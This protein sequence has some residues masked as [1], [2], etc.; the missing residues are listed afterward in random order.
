MNLIAILC[1]IGTFI[2]YIL[3]KKLHTKYPYMLLAPGIFVPFIIMLLMVIFNISY[4]TYMIE[5]KWIVWMLGPATIAF[6]IPI[7][8][9]RKVIKEHVLSI[10][11]GIVV[12]MIAGVISA[13]YLAKLFSFDQE[14]TYSLMARSISTPFAMELTSNIGGSVELVILFTMIT[15]IAGVAMADMILLALKLNS[16]FAQGAA[17]GNSAHGFGTSKAFM[18]HR[19]EGVVACLTMVLAGVFM[20][21]LGPGIVHLVVNIL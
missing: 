5:N 10:S 18:R 2:G 15:G 9:Y 1:F 20:V 19:E 14:T 4:D 21:L 3:S 17:L 12:G 11:L 8:E 7:Y 16:R 13:F 6:A